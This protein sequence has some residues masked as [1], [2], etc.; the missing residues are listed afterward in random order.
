MGAFLGAGDSS[1]DLLA[2]LDRFF[3]STTSG[4]SKGTEVLARED[5]VLWCGDGCLMNSGVAAERDT[6]TSWFDQFKVCAHQW[7]IAM[8]IDC[9]IRRL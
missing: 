5:H 4:L 8:T 3:G 1:K 9:R 2:E 6:S 7:L